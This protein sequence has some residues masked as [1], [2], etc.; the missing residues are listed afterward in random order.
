MSRQVLSGAATTQAAAPISRPSRVVTVTPSASCSIRATGADRLISAPPSSASAS[1]KLAV[2]FPNLSVIAAYH[3]H[4]LFSNPA[5]QERTCSADTSDGW[6]P[7]KKPAQADRYS[8]VERARPSGS[9]NALNETSR[10]A[11]G[12][13]SSAV[14]NSM[15]RAAW[16]T[17]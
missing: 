9:R 2:P 5:T 17:S 14:P 8:C 13:V 3:A 10:S 7:K 15:R 11:S 4:A 16:M 1:T 12:C 6:Q